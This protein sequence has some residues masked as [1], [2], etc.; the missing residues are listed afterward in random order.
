[1]QHLLVYVYV[2]V[3]VCAYLPACVMPVGEPVQWLCLSVRQA[4][5]ADGL[6]STG[7]D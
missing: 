7:L 1:M 6:D 3:C 4:C 5:V 2:S